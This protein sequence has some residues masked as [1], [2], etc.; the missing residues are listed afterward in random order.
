MEFLNK[1]KTKNEPRPSSKFSEEEIA[2][3]LSFFSPISESEASRWFEDNFLDES[4]H[5]Y[6]QNIE[7]AKY[8]YKFLSLC[9]SKKDSVNWAS[10]AQK[11]AQEFHLLLDTL[12]A[13]QFSIT[14]RLAIDY[15]IDET[16]KILLQNT[17]SQPATWIRRL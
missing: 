3:F 12:E 1:R 5:L 8:I 13:G 11:S 15:I 16:A 2:I 7:Y 6:L 14:F 9:E 17:R 4:N 10:F